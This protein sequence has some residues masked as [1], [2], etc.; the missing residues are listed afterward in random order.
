MKKLFKFKYPKIMLLTATIVLSYLIFRNP[1]ISSYFSHLGNLGYFGVFIG[2]ILFAFGFTAPFSVGLFISLAPSNIWIAGIVGGFGA[3]ISDLL[4]FKF[5]KISFEDEFKR[6]RKTRT[7]KGMGYLIQRSV[8]ERIKV[9]L[10]YVFAGILI[11]SPLPDEIGVVMLAGLTKINF[12]V[13][14]ILSF[15]LNTLGILIILSL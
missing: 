6:L 4:I 9:Y 15:I 8:G 1:S 13:L 12:K 3:L 11:A 7:I 5:I 2:G 14:A 10:M